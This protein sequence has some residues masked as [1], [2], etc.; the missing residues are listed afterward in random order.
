MLLYG[1]RNL[2]KS[3]LANI[4][5]VLNELEDLARSDISSSNFYHVVL[6]RLSTI[7]GSALASV[8]VPTE[9]GHWISIAS[10][11]E[12]GVAEGVLRSQI[13]LT[14]GSSPDCVVTEADGRAWYAVPIRPSKFAKGSLAVGFASPPSPTLAASLLELL[15]A[16][17]EILATRQGWDLESFLDNEWEGARASCS[18]LVGTQSLEEAATFW[19]NSLARNTGAARATLLKE[20]LSGVTICAVS[21]VPSVDGRSDVAK[22]LRA[23]G[24]QVLKTTKPVLLKRQHGRAADGSELSNVGENHLF[25][26]MLCCLVPAGASVANGE[27]AIAGERRGDSGY[28]VALE[29]ASYSDLVNSLTKLPQVL[30]MVGTAW[31]Q[32]ARWL[33]LPRYARHLL[34]GQRKLTRMMVP[35]VKWLLLAVLL[36]GAIWALQRPYPMVV[37][38]LGLFEPVTKRAIFATADGFIDEILVEDGELVERGQALIQLRSPSLELSLREAE[39]EILSLEE[40]INGTRIAMNQID[41]SSGDL[42]SDQ[43]RLAANMALLE[44]KKQTVQRKLELLKIQAERLVLEAPINGQ[45][46]AKD[47]SQQLEKRPVNRGEPLLQVVD[48]SGLWHLR[49]RV[50]DRDSGYVREHFATDGDASSQRDVEFVF[51]SAPEER[52]RAQVQ[53]IANQLENEHAEGCYL[54]IRAATDRSPVQKAHAGAGVHAYFECGEQPFWFV[55]CRPIVEAAQMRMWLSGEEAGQQ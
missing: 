52:L 16:F 1:F 33:S 19:V 45:V 18:R 47:L 29:F 5:R 39:G 37:E 55:W 14:D 31:Y 27:Q 7:T 17:C 24:K 42:A 54:E 49:L 20:G 10:H 26:N 13:D 30:P 35:S 6:E 9:T 41:P 8:L 40:E 43:S 3:D 25:P 50:A 34:V 28:A 36:I 53:W 51:D 44:T 21:N 23:I 11:G 46:V 48:L 32:H 15:S 12:G 4:D 2:L 22:S 38:S